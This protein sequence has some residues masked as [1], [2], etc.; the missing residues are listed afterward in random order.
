MNNRAKSYQNLARQTLK[1]KAFVFFLVPGSCQ[2]SW[3]R[4]TW[5]ALKFWPDTQESEGL[6]M[7]VKWRMCV[8]VARGVCQNCFD[9]QYGLRSSVEVKIFWQLQLIALPGLFSCL[10]LFERVWLVVLLQKVRCYEISGQVFR[11]L[12]SLFSDRRF[13]VAMNKKSS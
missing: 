6:H 11:I 4:K 1:N 7:G 13:G 12:S 2:A 9:C 5:N 8:K 3:S 10:V